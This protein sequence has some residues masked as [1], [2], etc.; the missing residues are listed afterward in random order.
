MAARLASRGTRLV[1]HWVGL[2]ALCMMVGGALCE[3]AGRETG[4][5]QGE[6]EDI[7]NPSVRDKWVG[8]FD[9]A[10]KDHASRNNLVTG[11]WS[12]GDGAT[13][14]SRSGVG[15]RK[16]NH[17]VKKAKKA[18]PDSKHLTPAQKKKMIAKMK[19]RASEIIIR[20]S[21]MRMPKSRKSKEFLLVSLGAHKPWLSSSP[22]CPC[23]PPTSLSN[24]SL[25]RYR[26]LILIGHP[27]LPGVAE[28]HNV[29]LQLQHQG[30]EKGRL[31]LSLPSSVMRR[32][33]AL[34]KL[35]FKD[36]GLKR[37]AHSWLRRV[38]PQALTHWSDA[39]T[40]A[41]RFA[42]RLEDCSQVPTH[43]FT[44][45]GTGRSVLPIGSSHGFCTLHSWAE[46]WPA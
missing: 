27:G 3:E 16:G 32:I 21:L 13:E 1:A 41:A 22:S 9:K 6:Q 30:G 29:R 44:G 35:N 40:P 7:T 28:E 36:N 14:P 24:S 38:W 4:L 46:S 19:V 39:G 45:T 12:K 15:G 10:E 20:L 37:I 34:N 42:S 18:L 31:L 2:A 17:Q 43:R 26:W 33:R 23:F 25:C 5:G 8:K 11:Y